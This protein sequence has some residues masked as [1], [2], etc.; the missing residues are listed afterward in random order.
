MTGKSFLSPNYQ[1]PIF[2]IFFIKLYIHVAV[3][4]RK[5]E[6]RWF[7]KSELSFHMIKIKYY[8]RMFINKYILTIKLVENVSRIHV[9]GLLQSSFKRLLNLKWDRMNLCHGWTPQ[10]PIHCKV[11][12]IIRFSGFQLRL[13]KF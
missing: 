10:K 12:Q 7:F 3:N 6:Q 13:A 4:P 5:P 9:H 1:L 8:R 2:E 11:I